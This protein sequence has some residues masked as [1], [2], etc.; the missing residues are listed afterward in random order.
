MLEPR[1]LYTKCEWVGLKY[2]MFY[3]EELKEKWNFPF[4]MPIHCRHGINSHAGW[5]DTETK[6]VYDSGKSKT[7]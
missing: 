2:W 1:D 3:E 6:W 4:I 7:Q 5:K